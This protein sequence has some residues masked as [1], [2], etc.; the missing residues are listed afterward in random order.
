MADPLARLRIE[1]EADS[2]SLETGLKNAGSALQRFA[3]IGAAVGTLLANV[4]M[5]AVQ[6]LVSALGEA[7]NRANE[8]AQA[9][10]N[11]GMSAE[12][13]SRLRFAAEQTGATFEQ[14]RSGLETLGGKIEEAIG[15]PASLAA[16]A[17]AAMG[18]ALEDAEGNARSASEVLRDLA[19]RFA[20]YHDGA[21]ESALATA[22]LGDAAAALLPMLN[23]GS[24]GLDSLADA[25][26]RAGATLSGDAARAMRALG[27]ITSQLGQAWNSFTNTLV[28][29]FAP[30]IAALAQSLF[31]VRT[32]F[33][34]LKF[35]LDIV[36]AT[37][38]ALVQA[39]MLVNGALTEVGNLL[40]AVGSALKQTFIDW[41]PGAAGRT[42][43]E[44][45]NNIGTAM[46]QATR[47]AA[48]LGQGIGVWET[49]IERAGQIAAPVITAHADMSA[50]I[51]QVNQLIREQASLMLSTPTAT[52]ADKLREIE[53]AYTTG[54]ISAARYGEMKRRAWEMEQRAANSTLATVGNALTAMFA[55][56]KPAAIA[57][58]LINTYVGITQALAS[59]P[60]PWSFVQ[61]AAV[62]AMG[63]AQVRN[64]TS[65]SE[66]G[67][68]SAPSVSAPTEAAGAPS[69]ML[70]VQGLSGEGLASLLSMRTLAERLLAFQADGGQVVL[71]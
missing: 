23:Q 59:L 31:N 60:P 9:A 25:S 41:D 47:D 18:I 22:V 27:D 51:R 4:V 14:L 1:L 42:I 20:A 45:W 3:A 15:D 30:A 5:Q 29:A 35:V 44:A 54:A 67:G 19:D 33:E 66:S 37:F 70:A 32:S 24:R 39:I 11:L 65:T 55:R 48:A 68:G 8:V 64:I 13:L 16:Q 10:R 12:S 38:I 49:T 7:A 36:K 26:D 2:A 62:A 40:V 43:T 21:E 34:S 69:Q 46:A 61:A 58:A 63:F 53:Y 57:Q 50:A 52:Y 6:G 28:N 71:Q 17:F 56:S